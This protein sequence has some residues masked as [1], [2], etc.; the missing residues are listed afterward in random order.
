[1][2]KIVIKSLGRRWEAEG[3][4]VKSTLDKFNLSWEQIKGKGTLRISNDKHTHTHLMPAP[5]LR[6]IFSNKISKQIWAK[7]LQLLLEG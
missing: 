5:V 7:N 2:Y 3:K 4:T 1:M 6:R